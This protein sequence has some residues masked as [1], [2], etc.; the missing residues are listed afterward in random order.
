M[1]EEE[2]PK[3]VPKT[4]FAR[5]LGSEEPAAIL[6]KWTVY[7]LPALGLGDKIDGRLEAVLG[8][9]PNDP[10]D[11]GDWLGMMFGGGGDRDYAYDPEIRPL[12][13]HDRATGR[14]YHVSCE[15][16]PLFEPAD[17]WYGLTEPEN[18]IIATFKEEVKSAARLLASDPDTA[19]SAT[20]AFDSLGDGPFDGRKIDTLMGKRLI[21]TGGFEKDFLAEELGCLE[22]RETW[23]ASFADGLVGGI[24]AVEKAAARFVAENE[25]GIGGAIRKQQAWDRAVSERGDQVAASMALNASMHSALAP[26]QAKRV[27]LVFATP[28][29]GEAAARIVLW[30][31]IDMLETG[32]PL[33][34]R[35]RDT[36]LL[37]D[38]DGMTYVDRFDG[39]RFDMEAL[40]AVRFRGKD[41]W[42]RSS[43][44]SRPPADSSL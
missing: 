9:K 42:T 14:L 5:W 36:E 17:D 37:D 25:I 7:R 33:T 29:G 34:V 26:L 19:A 38:F 16:K 32:E 35:T 31:L 41:L 13:L 1:T 12:C 15:A 21:A 4:E 20:E 30:R 23:G 44:E 8:F 18:R 6:S 28:E 27:V 22:V 3:L 10:H 11:A 39:R 43:F 40:K 24:D 2:R